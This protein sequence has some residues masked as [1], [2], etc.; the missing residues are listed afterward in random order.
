MALNRQRRRFGRLVVLGLGV[1]LSCG[2][3]AIGPPDVPQPSSVSVSPASATLRALADTVRLTAQVLDQNGR[4]IADAVVTWTSSADDVVAIDARGLARAIGNGEATITARA[5]S[6]A[7]GTASIM[8]S[9]TAAAVTVLPAADTLVAGDTVRLTAEAF[10][11]NGHAMESA[12]F[13]WSSSDPAVATVDSLGHL[14]ALN[15]GEAEIVGSSGAASGH[16]ELLV[17]A[18]TPTAIRLTPDSVVLSALGDTARLAAEVFDQAGRVIE[19][20]VVAWSS[21]DESVAT[22]D[23]TGLVAAAS[24]G[25]TAVTASSGAASGEARVAVMQIAGTVVVSPVAD[26]IAPGDTL[27]LEAGAFDANGHAIEEAEFSWSS[28]DLS[29]AMVDP[30]GLVTAAGTGTTTIS[31]TSRGATGKMELAV[32]ARAPT[33]IDVIPHTAALTAVSDT[34]R[35]VAVVLDRF[36]REIEDAVVSWSS[37][38]ESV[39]T[40]D[41]AGLISALGAGS[42]RIT[43]TSEAAFGAAAVTVTQNVD[44]IAVSPASAALS[45]GQRLRLRATAFDANGHTVVEQFSWSSSHPGVAT[46]DQKGLVQGADDGVATVSAQAG[47]VRGTSQI[48]VGNPDRAALAAFYAATEGTGWA[49]SDHWLTDRPLRDWY[50]VTLDGDGRVADLNLQENNVSGPIPP[51][52]GSLARLVSLDLERN[53]LTGPIPPALAKLADLEWL[54]LTHNQLTGP[55]PQE[56]GSLA[57]LVSLDLGDNQLTGPIPPELGKLFKLSILGLGRNAL[58]GAIPPELGDLASLTELGLHVNDLTGPIPRE[59][60][61][62][63]S[64]WS[65]TLGSNELTGPI[66]SEL[67]KLADLERLDFSANALTGSIPSELGKLSRLRLLRGQLNQLTGTIP[68]EIGRLVELEWLDLSFNPLEGPLPRSLPSIPNLRLF[69]FDSTRGVCAPGTTAFVRWL[70]DIATMHGP[71]CNTS[72]EGVLKSL[73]ET[74]GGGSWTRSEGWLGGIALEDWYGVTADSLGRVQALDL[75]RNGLVGRIPGSLAQLDH[76]TVLRMGGNALAGPVPQS[77]ARLPLRDFRYAGTSLCV[78]DEA[79]FQTW[80]NAIPVHEGTGETCASLLDREI[81]ATL[82]D[83]TGGIGWFRRDGWLTDAPLDE[84]YGVGVDHA[85]QVVELSLERNNM[86]GVIPAELGRLN[87]LASLKLRVNRLAGSIP[88]QLGNLGNLREL[89]AAFN[90]L[91]GHLPTELGSLADLEVLSLNS[92]ELTGTIPAELGRLV[93]LNH[94][95]LGGNE[96][97]GPLP[98][99]LGDLTSLTTLR[100]W[101]NR[102][103]GSIPAHLG[104]L[105]D[106]EI[107][108]LHSNEL[109][110]AIPRQVGELENL[111]Q[112][113][114]FGNGL[115]GSIPAELGRLANL[116]ELFL[117]DNELAGTVPREVGQLASLQ[118]LDLSNNQFAG[119]VPAEIGELASLRDLDLSNNQLEGS[120]PAE[121]GRLSRLTELRLS[122]NP[123]LAGALPSSLTA[124]AQLD[125]LFAVGTELCA[126]TD[127]DFQRWLAG[128][129][130]QRV[131]PCPE[132][133]GL[134]TAYLT[135]TVQSSTF[136]VPLV[137]DEPALL[138]VFVTAP[139]PTSERIPAVRATFYLNGSETHVADIPART[140]YLPTRMYE[141]DLTLSANAEVPADIMRPGLQMVVEVDPEGAVDASLGIERRIPATGRMTLDVQQL[142]GLDLTLIPFLW[143]EAPDSTIIELVAAMAADPEGHELLSQTRTLLP[144]ADLEV[145]AHEPVLSATEDPL[146]LLR[147]AEAIRVLE[148]GRGHYMGMNANFSTQGTR[149]IAFV[150]GRTSFSRPLARTM[151]HEL[152]HNMSLRHAP[153][154]DA[155]RPDPDYPHEVGTVGAWGYDPQEGGGLIPPERP[156]LMSYCLPSWISDYHFARAIRYRLINEGSGA[157]AADAGSS[158]S[159]LLWG[160]VDAEGQPFLEPA[161]FVDAPAALPAPGGGEFEVTGRTR[162]GGT[163]FSLRFDLPE[164][165]DAHAGSAFVFALPV[166]TGWARELASITL[167][168]AGGNVA[169]DR[170]TDRPMI[171]LRDPRSG[172]VR[173][174]MRDLP[175]AALAGSA[176]DFDTL[177]PERGLEVLF[178]RGLPGP[179]ERRR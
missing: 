137:A 24:G 154:G 119:G 128:V 22:V 72:D 146:D 101:G 3:D 109:T 32:V 95:N 166:E 54:D 125:T 164:I 98:P 62:L 20:V 7:S 38:D 71:F 120:V 151:A 82:Y 150:T 31:A 173:A 121:F 169:L 140:A 116:E 45:P 102:F 156:D 138:R 43:A 171:I 10:D 144:V 2:E 63:A 44:S 84:W 77:L 155:R 165:P 103:T 46:V 96:L 69:R 49:R 118:D 81:L 149:G 68:P 105:A 33:V 97:T 23:S 107:L 142:P 36:G 50:G 130:K 64:L 112:V 178:S 80:L 127:D 117:Q 89:D 124:L 90:Q 6:S 129:V 145:T 41:P 55:I 73:F 79:S 14:T 4:V 60:G 91:T 58:T 86:S 163:L 143:S 34:I 65:L 148:G 179:R 168:G 17:I 16:M 106:L 176:M 70:E 27:R 61:K 48:A 108:S 94:V 57:R 56:F 76:L 157:T 131:T 110:G 153:C 88:P 158:R 177:S 93:D 114:L 159:L 123:A 51:A 152:G 67:A 78:S 175:T 92:N 133:A 52:L 126:P 174:F 74:A 42:T 83:A 66:P 39:A 122:D 8:V 25:T 139:R 12:G 13:S 18:P 100:L 1:L 160:G 134:S 75:N 141:G 37:G 136:P 19:G 135:Q 113:W 99:E 147:E 9:Q 29:V 87:T 40:V 28:S 170:D 5:G 21:A 35:L 172:Q 104:S 30:G 15:S 53:Q 11:A 115:S 162:A 85:G 26:T 59:L 111:Q 47:E 161:F 167:S 132:G